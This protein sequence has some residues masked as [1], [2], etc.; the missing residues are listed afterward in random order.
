MSR[1]ALPY[2]VDDLSELARNLR[3]QLAEAGPAPG[4]VSLLNMLARAAGFRNFQHFRASAAA[5]RRLE[6]ALAQSGP[7]DLALVEK[8]LR[9]FDAEGRMARWP[10]KTQQQRLA[11][12]ALWSRLPADV[13]LSERE[14][15]DSLR[16]WHTFGDHALLRRTLVENALVT[17]AQDGSAY[18]RVECRPD[19]QATTLIR[20]LHAMG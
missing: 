11:A 4:H 18:R 15:N 12:F 16:R 20:R 2:Q 5:G 10:G 7:A 3:S 17:R 19:P 14:V 8:V 9:H 1:T 13:V 6:A